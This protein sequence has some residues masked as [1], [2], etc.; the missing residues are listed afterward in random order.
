MDGDLKKHSDN[1]GFNSVQ[2]MEFKKV[3]LIAGAFS[4]L[5]NPSQEV[6]FQLLLP[7]Q[8]DDLHYNNK[9]W[10]DIS[11]LLITITSR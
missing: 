10:V 5:I 8:S 11:L 4:G 7:F 1:P 6:F 2:D 9:T 3:E